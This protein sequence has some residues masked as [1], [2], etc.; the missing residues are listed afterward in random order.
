MISQLLVLEKVADGD[1]GGT[2]SFTGDLARCAP[3]GNVD[4]CTVESLWN[5]IDQKSA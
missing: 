4:V 1:R 3:G 2:S 5:N